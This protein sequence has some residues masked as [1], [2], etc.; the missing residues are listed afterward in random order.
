MLNDWADVPH[1]RIHPEKC[2]RP[3]ARG[4]VSCEEGTVYMLCLLALGILL[5]A[6]LG[7]SMLLITLTYFV[8]NVVYSLFFKHM[9][10]LDVSFIG[11]G[12]LLRVLAGGAVA[13]G[14]VSHWL[15]VLT[16]LLALII[17]LA[18]RRSEYLVAMKGHHFRKALRGYS[19]PF[20]DMAMTVCSTVVVMAY[21]MYCFS[22]KVTNRIG[23]GEIYYTAFLVI[24]G[25]GALFAADRGFWQ[26]RIAY[27]CT[28]PRYI[29][30]N[31]VAVVA[32]CFCLVALW[33]KNF[34][35]IFMSE[36]R[37]SK[38]LVP[39]PRTQDR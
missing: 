24:L 18:K 1:D 4:A 17:G 32:G 6:S 20:I 37:I 11:L 12:F 33:L 39:A 13:G 16:F 25:G 14:A 35:L 30:A 10:I 21:L 3:I 28:V 9:A 36:E 29:F 19:L 7:K 34:G 15:M 23:S 8:S 38:A 22:P 26:N 5:A 2:D 27:P 31:F